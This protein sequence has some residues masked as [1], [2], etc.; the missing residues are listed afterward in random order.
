MLFLVY[1]VKENELRSRVFAE[2]LGL[3]CGWNCHISL[4]SPNSVSNRK[5][6]GLPKEFRKSYKFSFGTDL[7]VTEGKYFVGK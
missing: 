4:K 6:V 7:F 3:E 2:R 5:S 1:F